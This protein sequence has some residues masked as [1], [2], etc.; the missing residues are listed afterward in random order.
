M[1][2]S[3]AF[4]F[5]ISII[6]F[7]FF[8]L[9]AKSGRPVTMQDGIFICRL[10]NNL[11][12]SYTQDPDGEYIL[13][14]LYSLDLK[15]KKRSII[16]SLIVMNCWAKTSDSTLVYAKENKLFIWNV[17]F[18]KSEAF[19]KTNKF[20]DILGLAFN[21]DFD[22]LIIF[23]I[24]YKKNILNLNVLNS[25]GIFEYVKKIDFNDMEMEGIHPEIKTTGRFIVFLEQENLYILKLM[26]EHPDLKLISDHCHTF[27]VY[28]DKGILASELDSE[29]HSTG[30]KIIS[31]D[32]FKSSSIPADREISYDMF[33]LITTQI[34]GKL[35]PANISSETPYLYSKTGWKKISELVLYQDNYISIFLYPE[36]GENRKESFGWQIRN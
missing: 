34:D 20:N 8:D 19:L 36:K 29:L 6:S 18:A 3:F 32:D 15:T 35:I 14:N 30:G 2:L 31:F 17:N 28:E 7:N 27:A 13:Y 22:K 26:K 16:D 21:S 12:Y 24:D 33:G 11:I 4:F 5:I 25:H 23:D 9:F 10:N 1:R